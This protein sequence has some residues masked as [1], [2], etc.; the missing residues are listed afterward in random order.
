MGV[1]LG[2]SIRPAASVNRRSTGFGMGCTAVFLLPFGAVGIGAALLA[3]RRAA[4][5]NLHEAL[6][7]L[8]FAVVFGGVAAGGW[9]LLLLAHRKMRT[10]ETLQARY[11]NQPWMWRSDWAS[12]RITDSNHML[13]WS[14]W[15]F[16]IFWNLISW[17]SAVL[18]VR[19]A[20]LQGN[21]AAYIAILFPLAGAGLLVWAVRNTIRHNR[22]GVS[23]L[24][25]STVP[26]VIGHSL[27]GNIRVS[28]LLQPAEGFALTLSCVQRAT[29]GGKNDSTSETILWQEEQQ[30]RGETFRDAA[31]MSTRVRVG[32][33]IPGDARGT[34]STIPNDQTIWRLSISADVPGIDYQSSFEVPVFRTTASELPASAEDLGFAGDALD[35]SEYRQPRESRISVSRTQRGTEIT[36]PAARNPGAAFT[37]TVFTVFWSAAMAFMLYLKAPVVFPIVFGLFELLLLIGTLQLWLGVSRVTAD[38]AALL[39]AQGYIYPGR[40]QKIASGEISTVTTRIGMQ[41]GSRPYYDVVVMR[42]SGKQIATGRWIRNK[43][44]AE[45]LAATIRDAL[46]LQPTSPAAP[47]SRRL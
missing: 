3:A 20:V 43:R 33:R 36:F 29:G 44:E 22:Y 11:P 46:G 10:D 42:R 35:L 27:A 39:I 16:A 37:L 24:E 32:F 23:L 4:Q 25:L 1:T 28:S 38:R 5:G 30:I 21:T 2:G 9:R 31:G 13:L 18:A 45:W 17:P 15:S 7:L 12:G 34:D 14:S 41:A 6:S 19:A 40:E 8:L 26:G 47:D